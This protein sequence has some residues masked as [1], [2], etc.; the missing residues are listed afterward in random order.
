MT[1]YLLVEKAE[2]G[3]WAIQFG[4]SDKETVEFE[5]DAYTEQGILKKNLKVIKS[6]SPQQRD[7]DAAVAK[8]NEKEAR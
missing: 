1:Y 7:C 5:R 2:G 6:A 8:L 3:E 4:D